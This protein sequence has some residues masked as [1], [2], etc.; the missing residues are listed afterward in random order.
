MARLVMTTIL[1]LFELPP[2]I[3]FVEDKRKY[4]EVLEQADLGNLR[5][6]IQFNIQQME[7][8]FRKYLTEA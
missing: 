5:P 3:I 2:L 1:A 7:K 8:T 4:I 6:F